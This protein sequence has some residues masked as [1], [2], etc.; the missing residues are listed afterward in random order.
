MASLCQRA[1]RLGVTVFLSHPER[2]GQGNA[3][4]RC[5]SSHA[6]G[7]IVGKH[8]KI[9]TLSGAEGMV[10]PGEA[11]TPVPVPPVGNVGLL[12]CADAYTPAIATALKAQGAQMLV[13][14]AAW[15]PGLHGP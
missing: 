13:S 6:D 10:E 12:I 15:G 1:A 5:L 7:R 11:V 2:D 4:I 3:T 9:H 8:R 14:A